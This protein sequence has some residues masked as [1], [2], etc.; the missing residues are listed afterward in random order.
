MSV[1]AAP[2][3]PPLPGIDTADGLRRMMNKPC[4]YTRVLCDFHARFR[5]ERQLIESALAAG[6]HEEASR[7]AHSLKGLAGT[8]GARELQAQAEAMQ[9]RCQAGKPAP[10]QW[11]RFADELARVLDGIATAFAL[12]A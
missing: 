9:L 8:V 7:R 11:Q 1:D 10:E 4:L 12:P 3:I 2:E 6:N 5:D